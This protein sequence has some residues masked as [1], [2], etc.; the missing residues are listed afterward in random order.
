MTEGSPQKGSLVGGLYWP[1]NAKR[2][3]RSLLGE[4]PEM[5]KA[6]GLNFPFSVTFSCSLWPFHLC[7]GIRT[8]IICRI[9]DFQGT[10]DP[11]CHCVLLLRPHVWKCLALPD[12]ASLARKLLAARMEQG[13]NLAPAACFE[14]RKSSSS[15]DVSQARDH[16]LGLL[17]Q[18]PA[19]W[20]WV[21]V[22][23]VSPVSVNKSTIGDHEVSEDMNWELQD[24]FRLEMQQPSSFGSA[25]S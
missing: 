2:H 14:L 15:R 8:N 19:T 5:D 9:I 22:T 12:E 1:A 11:C 4:Q 6:C 18:G 21:S 7:V 13:G 10:C 25:S 24:L 17:L 3:P 16:S 23:A 20:K